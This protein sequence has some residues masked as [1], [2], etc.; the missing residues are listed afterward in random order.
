MKHGS[1]SVGRILILIPLIGGAGC[2]SRSNWFPMKVGQHWTYEVRSGFDIRVESIKVLRP[3]TVAGADGFELSGPLGVSRL[4]WRGDELWADRSANVQFVPS[5][6]LFR[7]SV[8]L[9]V[10][11]SKKDDPIYQRYGAEVGQWE[12]KVIVMGH[13][14]TA[15]AKLYERQESVEIKA[16]KVSAILATLKLTIDRHD[17]ELKS[18]YQQGV[19]LVQQEQRTGVTRVVRLELKSHGD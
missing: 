3:L 9:S 19:G 7:P 4:A 11:K 16:R 1:L 17:V 10:D 13:E 6:L 2:R 14:R 15:S 12:G 8:D 18:W 5:L